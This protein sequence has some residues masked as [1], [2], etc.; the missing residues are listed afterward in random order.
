[1]SSSSRKAVT[2]PKWDGKL[3]TGKQIVILVTS[4]G[5]ITLELD[6]DVAP[7]TVTNF[8]TLAKAGYYDDVTFHRVIP[9]FMIQGGDP[10]G[11]GAGGAS[12]YGSE[13]ADEINP[14]A[15]PY[16]T[17][18]I[19]G[20]V[21]EISKENS[22]EK[23]SEAEILDERV[24]LNGNLETYFI[25]K[26]K[27]T[28]TNGT[29]YSQKPLVKVGDI[30]KAGDNLIDGPASENGELALG[31]NLTIAYMHYEGYGYEDAI[32]VSDRL[33]R[34][35]KLTSIHIEEYDCEVVDTKLGP[36][37]L[38]RDIPNV[39]ESDLANLDETGIVVIG[40]E[41]GPNDILVGKIAPKGE[42]E[43]S[44]EERLLRA[45]FGEKAREVRD[46]SLRM[47]HGE[48]GTVIGVNILDKELGDELSPGTSKIIK[49][50]VAQMRKVSIGDKVA[51]R[52][53]NKG[54]IS[55]I[56]PVADMPYLPDGTPI[57]FIISPLSVIGRMNLG[58]LALY[59]ANLCHPNL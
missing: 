9:D 17:G 18:Y 56:V 37:E 15:E 47:P 6:A 31:T 43:L 45:I 52:H 48:R 19:E 39:G 36:E 20:V 50:K 12:I 57:D 54:V 16:K 51:G 30:V 38:T 44:A 58:Q 26:F 34:E 3:L 28:D 55:R 29:S 7:K 5:N 21:V 2:V 32:I 49:V 8:V 23:Q 4:M 46:T 11:T 53:G 59:C 35:D 10:D 41:V 27:K 42:T 25:T 24:K 13:F 22:K 14:N 1:M 40:A 33:V